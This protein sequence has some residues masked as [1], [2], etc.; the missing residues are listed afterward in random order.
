MYSG[1]SQQLIW[2]IPFKLLGKSVIFFNCSDSFIKNWVQVGIVPFNIDSWRI[3]FLLLFIEFHFSICQIA[4]LTF[5]K[6]ALHFPISLFIFNF[7]N[8]KVWGA[9]FFWKIKLIKKNCFNIHEFEAIHRRELGISWV[10]FLVVSN[11]IRL[12]F[13]CF[14]PFY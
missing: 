1:Q 2:F 8:K 6:K 13:S 10:W 5:Q 14:L 7:P 9:L 12:S 3:F 4:I 11:R